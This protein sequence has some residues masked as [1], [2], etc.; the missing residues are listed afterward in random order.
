M[1]YSIKMCITFYPRT[2]PVKPQKPVHW[3]GRKQCLPWKT[4]LHTR[5]TWKLDQGSKYHVKTWT[6]LLTATWY[7]FCRLCSY[8]KYTTPIFH[9]T[10]IIN[11][12]ACSVNW[13]WLLVF[14][15]KW[16]EEWGKP[17]NILTGIVQLIGSSV[18][19]RKKAKLSLLCYIIY[20]KAPGT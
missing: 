20:S 14:L 9:L 7:H 15:R 13:C 1:N 19:A 5:K 10:D 6:L 2:L 16:K 12:N 11:S 18:C 3:A 8:T 17:L 4:M